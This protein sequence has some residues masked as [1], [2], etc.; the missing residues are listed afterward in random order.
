MAIRC[1][2][3]LTTALFTE[4]TVQ[5]GRWAGLLDHGPGP[6]RGRQRSEP[7]GGLDHPRRS[8]GHGRT[9]TGL[10][11][12][13]LHGDRWILTINDI[14]L[15]YDRAGGQRDQRYR[16][17]SEDGIR[18]LCLR[19]CAVAAAMTQ[20]AR[21]LED[22]GVTLTATNCRDADRHD[23][24]RHRRLHGQPRGRGPR[25]RGRCHHPGPR[26][27]RSASSSL[28]T[29]APSRGSCRAST[30][31]PRAMKPPSKR[32]SSTSIRP[33]PGP[34]TTG[35]DLRGPPGWRRNP[36]RDRQSGWH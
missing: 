21:D 25:G 26:S 29:G 5:P 27:V 6:R 24:Q 1:S 4:A 10:A 3:A 19:D 18:L 23:C 35:R 8:D 7:A 28:M 30:R 16:P 11:L 13:P 34:P 9:G 32:R 31:T 36:V 14:R 12:T 2:N 17:G 15:V 33:I 22:I 20:T